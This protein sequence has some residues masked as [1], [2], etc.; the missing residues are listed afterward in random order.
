[1]N[2]VS[3]TVIEFVKEYKLEVSEEGICFDSRLLIFT[4][5]LFAQVQSEVHI[6]NVG[7]TN[8][9]KIS[10]LNPKLGIGNFPT[11]FEP[12]PADI[13]FEPKKCLIIKGESKFYGM[14]KLILEPINHDCAEPTI[15]EIKSKLYN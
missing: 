10:L 14:F 5:S 9:D 1:M 12:E 3:A 15:N 11:E 6:I 4:K 7:V 2:N 13:S 8:I